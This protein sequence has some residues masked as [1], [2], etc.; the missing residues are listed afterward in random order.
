MRVQGIRLASLLALA[1][2]IAVLI[3]GVGASGAG[4]K[5]PKDQCTTLVFQNELQAVFGRVK[6]P[7][8]AQV[9]LGKVRRVGFQNA[10]II[11]SA[12]GEYK[13][14][15]RGIETWEVGVDLQD[16]ARRVGFSITLECVRGK[17]AGDIQAILGTRATSAD[18]Q[19]LAAR[20]RDRGIT[21]LKIRP[22]PCGGFQAY[23]TGFRTRAQA[24]EFR[25]NARR[26]GFPETIVVVND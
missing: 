18:V 7:A 16:E 4:P 12:C 22:A 2:T 3:P 14:F 15:Q 25:D 9:L 5:R 20:A 17:G 21:S 6:T 19:T 11:R 26:V 23:V 24:E 1:G 10:D 13:V 8:A